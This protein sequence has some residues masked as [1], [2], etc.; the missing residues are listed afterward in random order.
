M[1]GH[2][3]IRG[4]NMHIVIPVKRNNNNNQKKKYDTS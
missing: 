4:K 1:H 2:T 3:I